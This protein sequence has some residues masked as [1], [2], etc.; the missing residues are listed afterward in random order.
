MENIILEA[1]VGSFYE[2]Q[3]A[4]KLGASRI[5]L[6]DNLA[7]GGTTPS[8]GTILYCKE[9]LNIPSAVMIRPRGGNFVYSDEEI[10]I[11]KLDIEICKKVV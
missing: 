7:E 1:C 6:C 3:N 4:M 10:N 11:M 2:A 8:Y 5:E 9:K